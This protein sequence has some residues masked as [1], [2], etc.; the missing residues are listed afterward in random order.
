MF[1]PLDRLLADLTLP[2]NPLPPLRA[3]RLVESE[4]TVIIRGQVSSYYL[5]QMAQETVL[6]VLQGRKLVNQ[7]RVVQTVPF[8]QD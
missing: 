1:Y 7:V 4:T 6:P 2:R 8:S 5:K 3:L